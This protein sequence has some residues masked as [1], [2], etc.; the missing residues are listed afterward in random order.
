MENEISALKIENA[1]LQ[2]QLAQAQA[3]N[4]AAHQVKMEKIAD[5]KEKLN[6]KDIAFR[7]ILDFL[8]TIKANP[9][10]AAVQNQPDATVTMTVE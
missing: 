4:V 6:A 3:E 7:N 8:A 10:K 5:L 2:A 9:V 1:R